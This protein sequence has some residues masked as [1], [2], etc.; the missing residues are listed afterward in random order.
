MKAAKSSNL[1]LG[2][3]S[4]LACA[5]AYMPCP[6]PSKMPTSMQTPFQTGVLALG[7]IVAV[8]LGPV[9]CKSSTKTGVSGPVG[10]DNGN[11]A[12][13]GAGPLNG[14]AI[15]SPAATA[16]TATR[17]Q[18]AGGAKARLVTVDAMVG[19]VNGRALYAS[20]LLDPI[21]KVLGSL[22]RKGLSPRQM[23]FE[24]H[25]EVNRRIEE[26]IFNALLVAEA[27][28]DLEDGALRGVEYM[29]GQQRSELVRLHGNGSPTKADLGLGGNGDGRAMEYELKRYRERIVIRNYMHSK[30]WIDI[31]VRRKDIER[32]YFNHQNKFNRPAN[33][34]VRFIKISNLSD[35]DRID[36][37]LVSGTPFAEVTKDKANE[38]GAGEQEIPGGKLF[39][40]GLTEKVSQ[41]KPGEHTGRVAI[42]GPR[43]QTVYWWVYVGKIDDSESKSLS[44]A[45]RKI[46]LLLINQQR[47]QLQAK[48][49]MRLLKQISLE[50]RERMLL[51]LLEVA[52]SRYL[53]A[54]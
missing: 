24:L 42:K 22:G 15:P 19:Q 40:P 53:G 12:T 54:P 48:L 37:L 11:Q 35:A 36:G 4:R 7:L 39:D 50:E 20:E 46:Y 29:V 8:C 41:L 32:Y 14:S 34:L 10:Q 25:R 16:S 28:R 27:R 30:V 23:R 21:K 47:T 13:K 52:K 9:G 18:S 49:R 26:Y 44:E 51:A 6:I 5:A 43:Q 45:Q 2:L 33:W 38:F 31:N 1:T 3:R 17:A